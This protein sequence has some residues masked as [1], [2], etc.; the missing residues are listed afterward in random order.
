VCG[1]VLGDGAVDGGDD[2]HPAA[3]IVNAPRVN[4]R[5]AEIEEI[6]ENPEMEIGED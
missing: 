3:T 5:T 1:V 6:I 2:A 4:A